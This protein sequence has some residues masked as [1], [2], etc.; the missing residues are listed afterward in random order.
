MT[1]EIEQM[2][3]EFE[4]LPNSRDQEAQLT[5]EEFEEDVHFMKNDKA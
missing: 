2:W 4:A 3:E 1:T 5:R